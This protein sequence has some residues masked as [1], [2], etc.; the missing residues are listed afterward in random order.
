MCREFR[1]IA[2]DACARRRRFVITRPHRSLTKVWAL[3][4]FFHD[5]TLTMTSCGRICIGR[6]KINLSRVFAGQK[7]G[8][9]KVIEKICHS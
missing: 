8:V 4:Y 6:R 1:G 9:K 5:Q 3:E 7:V 2:G